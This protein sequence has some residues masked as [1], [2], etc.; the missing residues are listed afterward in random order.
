M[1]EKYYL[2]KQEAAKFQ[3]TENKINLISEKVI[4]KGVILMV[5]VF[6][7]FSKVWYIFY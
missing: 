7:N 2:L 5:W 1:E 4:R 6:L 3:D